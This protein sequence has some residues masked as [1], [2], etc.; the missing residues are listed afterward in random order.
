[1][2]AV[3]HQQIILAFFPRFY[4]SEWTAK[5]KEKAR[6]R[7]EH[8]Q[9]RSTLASTTLSE[10][11]DKKVQQDKMLGLSNNQSE[12]GELNRRSDNIGR[13]VQR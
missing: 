7:R 4:C 6:K 8:Q 5:S 2:D 12:N 13:E 9:M 3:K 1:M 11:N 10:G